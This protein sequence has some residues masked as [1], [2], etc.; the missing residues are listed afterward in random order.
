MSIL[1]KLPKINLPFL[2][3]QDSGEYYFAL[4][5]GFSNVTAAVWGIE[6]GRLEIISSN[7]QPYASPHDLTQAANY[8]LDIALADFLPEPEQVLFGVPETWLQDE[9]LKPEYLEMLKKM[10]KEL[11]LSPMAYVS[12]SHAIAHLLQKQ[13]GAPLA[14]VLVENTDPLNVSVVKSGKVV[15]SKKHRRT[16]DLP[17]DIERALVAFEGIEVLPS[18]I[19]MV[20]GDGDG[21]LKEELS[22][23][24]WMGHLPFLHLPKIEIMPAETTLEAIC[25][26]GASELDPSVS[27][28]PKHQKENHG[29]HKAALVNSMDDEE[30][31]VS[32][33]HSRRGAHQPEH[34][35]VGSL[36]EE[37]ETA[38]FALDEDMPQTHNLPAKRQAAVMEEYEEE[39]DL[40]VASS[41]GAGGGLLANL[42]AF[43]PFGGGGAGRREPGVHHGGGGVSN[44]IKNKF[45]ILGFV[46]ILGL[47]AAYVFLLKAEVKLFIDMQTLSKDSTIIADPSITAVDESSKKIPGTVL[48]TQV[49]GSAKGTA[50]GKKQVGE[51]AKGTVIIY[52]KTS[53]PKSLNAGTILI[54]P[55]NLQFKID[56]GVEI[57]SQSAVDGGISFGKATVNATAA[58]IGPDSNIAAGKELSIK[59]ISAENISAKVDQAFSGGVSKD[60]AV[61]T[62][63][64]QKK[65]LAQLSSELR[66]K[67][68]D[69]IQAK[70][71]NGFKIIESGIS[72]QIISQN[73]SKK[74]GD[75]A[76]DFTLEMVAKYKG[77]AYN[78][79]DLK[80]LVSKMLNTNVPE[81]F[82][83]DLSQSTTQ[84]E[85]TQVGKDGT[86]TFTAKYN[87]KLKPKVDE[88]QIKKSI[89][90]LSKEAADNKLREI[91][92]VIGTQILI[93]PALPKPLDLLPFWPENIN[94]EVTAK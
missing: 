25:F 79:A 81:G 68:K 78:E 66:T 53:G 24:S 84:A 39:P 76:S 93:K 45:L 20:G 16:S 7:V 12:T 40:P 56:T 38:R 57:A 17:K 2:S 30:E 49:E 70:L 61:V 37:G 46:L 67:S 58:Q 48:D 59:D 73:Y 27:F 90:G 14:A 13:Q 65:L 87:A 80:T 44:I 83:L 42:L 43:L 50:T 75:Q 31:V 71:T 3:K 54:G 63:D 4:T 91:K 55:D 52:N 85:I 77:T 64:D 35:E 21:K 86:L 69:Q 51:S 34:E 1:D 88:A 94:L 29:H 41:A 33:H 11:G 28:H 72:E 92:N 32:P 74:V 18:K 89:A 9:N 23:Y 6:R 19:I 5:I 15:G 62:A 22:G 82:E 60:V 10:V 36:E 8:A 47:G 26:A